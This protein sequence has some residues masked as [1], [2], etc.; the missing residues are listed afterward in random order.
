M[1]MSVNCGESVSVSL[2]SGSVSLRD[3]GSSKVIGPSDGAFRAPLRLCRQKVG[4]SVHDLEMSGG[5]VKALGV[6][7]DSRFLRT[8]VTWERYW[9]GPLL[10][11]GKANGEMLEVL[12]GHCT[13][14]PRWFG[15]QC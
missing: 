12:V 2:L 6:E 9:L 8:G 10:A 4:L 1:D 3:R 13:Y 5:E 7:L 15:T 14:A 11:R